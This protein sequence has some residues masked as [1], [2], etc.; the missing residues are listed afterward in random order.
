MYLSHSHTPT[1]CDI[2]LQGRLCNHLLG[3]IP[4]VSGQLFNSVKP[5]SLLHRHS[6]YDKQFYSTGPRPFWSFTVKRVSLNTV[7]YRL[8]I[9]NDLELEKLLTKFL[10]S[11]FMVDAFADI[12]V[13][14][15]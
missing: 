5:T 6:F 7:K 12:S 9:E 11:F 8:L 13:F 2:C 1:Q 3:S 10:R 15:N 14:I 4:T